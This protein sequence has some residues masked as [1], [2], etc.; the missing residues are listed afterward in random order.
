MA[1]GEIHT[2]PAQVEAVQLKQSSRHEALKVVK[3]LTVPAFR[4]ILNSLDVFRRGRSPSFQD[5]H[6]FLKFDDQVKDPVVSFVSMASFGF[7]A[8]CFRKLFFICPPKDIPA[9]GEADVS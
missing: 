5:T 1:G 9:P 7:Q 8:S 4:N 6:A 2:N 3:C